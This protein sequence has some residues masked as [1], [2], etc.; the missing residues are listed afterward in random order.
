MILQ[1]L[2]FTTLELSQI[3]VFLHLF[4]FQCYFLSNY[5]VGIDEHLFATPVSHT[6][7]KLL[8]LKTSQIQY[9]WYQLKMSISS[10]IFLSLLTQP[11]MP[12][13]YPQPA[14]VFF[15]LRYSFPLSSWFFFLVLF[16]P[17]TSDFKFLVHSKQWKLCRTCDQF[18]FSLQVGLNYFEIIL[19]F[20]LLLFDNLFLGFNKAFCLLGHKNPIRCQWQAFTS[21]A[22]TKTYWL[23]MV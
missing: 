3:K 13:G 9:Y 10:I 14:S 2:N 21:S 5:L 7:V 20:P 12:L 16:N 17:P 18:N 1:P 15:F 4:L 11:M 6:L 23:K 8:L 22:P 19:V